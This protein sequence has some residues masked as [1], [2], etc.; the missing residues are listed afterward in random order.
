MN[1]RDKPFHEALVRLVFFINSVEILRVR[2]LYPCSIRLAR[3]S[4]TTFMISM[5]NWD[6]G[7]RR[8]QAVI[9]E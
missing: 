8:E 4:F 5:Q 2:V 3:D 9:V 1:S 6:G 7:I